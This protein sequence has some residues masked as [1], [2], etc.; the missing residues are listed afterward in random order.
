MKEKI[1]VA[2]VQ[3]DLAWLDPER[4][5]EKMLNFVE[6]VHRDKEIDLIVFP[7]LTNTGYVKPRDREFGREYI[8]KAEKIPGPFTDALCA[9]AKKH[10]LYLIAGLCELHP[11]IPASLYNSAVLISPRGEIVG[12]H[13]K[14]HIPGEEKHYFYPGSTTDVYKTELGNIGLAICYDAI[15]PEL[16]RILSI[17]GAEII[18]A[19]FN[20]PRFQP[21]DRFLH[22]ACTRAY[23]NRN[24]FI[25]CNRV[26]KE[27]VE[28]SG[29]SIIA[30]PDGQVLSRTVGEGEEV[31]YA[32]LYNDHLLEARAFLPVFQ[33]R[34]PDLYEAIVRR[35]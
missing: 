7:E 13:H 8:K 33:D 1:E 23:E 14:L 27:D 11:E 30:G 22:I 34:R 19:V 12:I 20:G 16:P 6:M 10:G 25:L 29:G 3:M 17:K 32:T 18:C 26:G 2:A 9:A 35:F 4:N 21:Y 24:Y 15:F 31:V 28:F 5:L